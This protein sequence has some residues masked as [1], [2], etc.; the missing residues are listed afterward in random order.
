[1]ITPKEFSDKWNSNV[2]PLID[3]DIANINSLALSNET[4]NFL[5]ESGLPESAAPFLN[6]E[7]SSKGGAT[8]LIEK[9]GF[10]SFEEK[11]IYCN[12][13]I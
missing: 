7:S 5:I 6:F 10:N 12:H 9:F 1:M 4:K 11:Y 8:K 3:Y 2:F 13:L